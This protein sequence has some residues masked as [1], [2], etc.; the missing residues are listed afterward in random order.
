MRLK[1]LSAIWPPFY[2]LTYEVL[3]WRICMAVYILLN[4]TKITSLHF[5]AIILSAVWYLF[6][7]VDASSTTTASTTTR[8]TTI[9]T[10]TATG[11][12]TTTTSGKGSNACLNK[13]KLVQ[14]RRLLQTAFFDAFSIIKMYTEIALNFMSKGRIYNMHA[15]VQVVSLRRTGT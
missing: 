14:N 6:S 4:C 9:R 7:D 15:L 11:T 3:V 12:T 13:L 1:I 5:S 2:G 10:T 8:P